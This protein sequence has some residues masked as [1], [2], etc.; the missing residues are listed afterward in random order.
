M[1]TFAFCDFEDALDVLRSAITEASITT[2]IDQ[3]DQQFNAG[4]LD[5]SPA[6]WGHL[7]SEVMV[8]LDHVRQSA[9]SV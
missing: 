7:A 1:T 4:Y 5:V 3:I 6:Q 2:L 8:R 9:P